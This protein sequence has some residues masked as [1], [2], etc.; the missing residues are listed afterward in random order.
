MKTAEIT[1]H[2]NEDSSPWLPGLK[3]VRELLASAPGRVDSVLLRKGG[4]HALEELAELCRAAKVRFQYVDDAQL[5]RAAGRAQHQGVVARLSS[6]LRLEYSDLLIA[7]FDAPLPLLVALDQ[8]QDPGNVGALARTLHALG[9]AGLVLPRHNS[10]FLG[11]GAMRASAG[12]L[13]LLPVAEVT[14]LGRA[15]QEAAAGGLHTYAAVADG[16]NALHAPLQLPALLVLGNEDKGIRPG[17]AQVCQ[18]RLTIP[19][20]RDFDSLNVAQA[21]GILTSCFARQH[22]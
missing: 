18:S 16:E 3:P 22:P 21:G 4:G 15:V 2:N 1:Q 14:N 17:V 11:P 20:A 6:A 19:F 12:A 7:A 13:A 9:A 10:A 8:V 5:G